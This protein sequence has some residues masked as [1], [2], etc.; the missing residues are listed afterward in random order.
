MAT[1]VERRHRQSSRLGVASLTA[2]TLGAVALASI[3]VAYSTC[4][5]RLFEEH[6]TEETKQKLARAKF[7]AGAERARKAEEKRARKAQRKANQ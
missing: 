7:E 4:Y 3:P 2:A 1:E 5:P 6:T